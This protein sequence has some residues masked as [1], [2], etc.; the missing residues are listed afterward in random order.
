VDA[1]PQVTEWRLDPFPRSAI[2]DRA[3]HISR[4]VL[5]VVQ[6]KLPIP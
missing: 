6:S 5:V 2:A 3:W 1:R 4:L